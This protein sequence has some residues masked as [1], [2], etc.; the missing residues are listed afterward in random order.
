MR[1]SA[2]KLI[3]HGEPGREEPG[4]L[5]DDGR[6][7]DAAGEFHDFD[8]GFFAA[9]GLEALEQ[10]VAEGCPGGLELEPSARWGAPVDRPSKI[11]CVGKNYLDH[12]REFGEGAP[13]EPVL[14]M[15][16]SSVVERAVR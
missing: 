3:R 12:A 15:K 2:M 13:S 9:G 6:R 10:W 1:D 4:V 11:V 5:L 16:A 7:I 8:E 14:F